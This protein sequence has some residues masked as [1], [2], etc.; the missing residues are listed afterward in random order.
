MVLTGHGFYSLRKSL[1]SYQVWLQAYRKSLK[2]RPA[3]AAEVAANSL[4]LAGR[5]HQA[6]LYS[7]MRP[8][9]LCM[10]LEPNPCPSWFIGFCS[11]QLHHLGG[12]VG[13]AFCVGTIFS[14]YTPSF[15]ITISALI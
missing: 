7:W 12:P 13:C 2:M 8:G 9:T 15:P 5:N 11:K 4:D 14:R 6:S 3:S 1:V 10:L